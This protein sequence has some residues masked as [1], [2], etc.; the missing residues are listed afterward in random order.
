MNTESSFRNIFRSF[1]AFT[2][3]ELLVVIAIIAILASMMLPA[4]VGAKARAK[5]IHCV[6]NLRQLHLAWF[7]YANDN[8]DDL[9]PTNSRWI[10]GEG[11]W[12]SV[13]D[14]WVRGNAQLDRSDDNLRRGLLWNYIEKPEVYRCT[15]DQSVVE[16]RSR[17]RFRF[18]SYSLSA[19][20]NFTD[21]VTDEPNHI[22]KLTGILEPSMSFTFAEPS[23][24]TIDSGEF[25]FHPVL[26]DPAWIHLPAWR[27]SG[28]AN[29]VFADGGAIYKKWD[30][31]PKLFGGEWPQPFAN[32]EDKND[33]RW[34]I[35]RVPTEGAI[36]ANGIK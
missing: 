29:L 23:E 16:F 30:Y 8:K 18:R 10:P 24:E 21:G 6:G 13:G 4:L 34:L 36:V 28:G 5:T 22:F 33:F 1:R 2:L 9:V 15:S 25:A 26:P 7:S 20:L 14:S 12:R 32:E 17:S 11:V 3:I 35:R 27:H 31:A 19:G